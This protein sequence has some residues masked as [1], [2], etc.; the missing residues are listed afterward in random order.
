MNR[1]NFLKTTLLGLAGVYGLSLVK[2]SEGNQDLLWLEKGSKDK[3]AL[4]VEAGTKVHKL[5]F[6]CKLLAAHAYEGEY[7]SFGRSA[8]MPSLAI[9]LQPNAQ[10]AYYGLM[11]Q[12]IILENQ[13][14]TT[15]KGDGAAMLICARI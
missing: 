13:V 6:R 14:V 12:Y 2:E 1:R 15:F 9:H 3:L 5:P 7:F 10:W 4:M 11:E 8:E